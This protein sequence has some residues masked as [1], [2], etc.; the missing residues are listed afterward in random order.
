MSD[1]LSEEE[2][3]A[4]LKSWWDENG[5]MLVAA[6][7]V[8]IGGI[9]G[10]RYYDTTR[11]EDIA[12]AADLYADYLVAEG[13]T[14]DAAAAAVGERIPNTAYHALVILRGASTSV[15]AEE[16][17]TAAAQLSEA[18]AA[19]P[20]EALKDLV[21]VRLARVQQQLDRSDAAL[22]TLAEVRGEGYRPVVAELK[23]DIHLERG[24][25]A[26]AH[27][28]YQSALDALGDGSQKPLLELKV[29]DTADA[30]DA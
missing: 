26:L 7:V 19:A 25:R 14:R 24:E 27:E 2:Q 29:A 3:I 8:G 23:G 6:I 16:F 20:T 22:A 17:E 21:R 18:L 28:A 30:A 15:E 11:T 12:A 10:W 5:V 13:E 9:V 4:R 1:Y